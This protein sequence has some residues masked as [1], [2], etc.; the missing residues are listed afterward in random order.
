[1]NTLQRYRG[2]LFFEL[3]LDD[4]I[5]N[6]HSTGLLFE[7]ETGESHTYVQLI[8]IKRQPSTIQNV[9]HSEQDIQLFP[10]V[11]SF[12]CTYT[13]IAQESEGSYKFFLLLNSIFHIIEL[14]SFSIISN[15]LL[16]IIF[17]HIRTKPPF[18]IY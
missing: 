10:T 3:L 12:L 15:C 6:M 17:S 2:W 4:E 8:Q 5:A 13:K 11:A 9:V 1:M 14:F 7:L 18:P 16:V